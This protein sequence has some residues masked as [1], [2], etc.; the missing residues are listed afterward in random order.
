MKVTHFYPIWL[1]QIATWL[2]CQRKYL[3]ETITPHIV[4]E[5]TAILEKFEIPNMHFLT[6]IRAGI[7]FGIPEFE[8]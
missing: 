7:R 5:R 4:R 3:L 2:Y 8:N 6:D 1:P